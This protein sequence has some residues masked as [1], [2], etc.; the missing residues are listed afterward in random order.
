VAR[1]IKYTGKILVDLIPKIYDTPRIVRILGED[2]KEDKA[3]IDPSSSK[4][5]QSSKART[6]SGNLQPIVG[7]YD[8]TVS[9]RPKLRTRAKKHSSR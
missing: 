3:Q 7:R 2:G 6:A 4:P 8:V 1:A 9:S 5:M